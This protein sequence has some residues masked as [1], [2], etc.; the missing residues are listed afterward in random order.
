MHSS[1]SRYWMLATA[2]L[3]SGIAIG[4]I[5]KE[6]P[7]HA[8]QASAVFDV[9][10]LPAKPT[11]RGERRDIIDAP[12]ATFAQLACHVSTLNPGEVCHDGHRHPEE[13][14]F[15]VKDGNIEVTINDHT[16]TATTG[17]VIFIS[18]NDFH[19]LK[20]LSTTAPASYYVLKIAATQHASAD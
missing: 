1:V 15:I 7:A 3:V 10:K 18:S 16:E 13:E 19:R 8:P 17:A 9:N 2:C 11:K 5:V 12:T 6:T 4:A 14:L 20:N